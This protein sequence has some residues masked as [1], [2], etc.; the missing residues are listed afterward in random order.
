[1]TVGDKVYI[2]D[3][4]TQ[5]LI[6]QDTTGILGN[7]PISGG[8]DWSSL[9]YSGT[10][11]VGATLT[12]TTLREVVSGSGYFSISSMIASFDSDGF[13]WY[14]ITIDGIQLFFD[15]KLIASYQ[16]NANQYNGDALP[17]GW[18]R[19]NQSY[20]VEHKRDNGRLYSTV[21]EAAE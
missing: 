14:T 17:T 1:M 2:A 20:K 6:K 21:M 15:K 8:T 3:K 18:I 10:F 16:S 7:F 4:A 13:G 11:S 19:Y 9:T 5:D 12:Y